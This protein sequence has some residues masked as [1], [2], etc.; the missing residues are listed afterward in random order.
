MSNVRTKI[1][2]ARRRMKEALIERD[3]EIDIV[4]ISLLIRENPLLV[5]PPGTAKSLLIDSLLRWFA[6]D[7]K[8]FSIIL[9]KFSVPEELFGPISL[10]E[11]KNGRYVRVTT[12][13]LPEAHI[14][15]IDE[16]FKASPAILNTMLRILN[17]RVFEQGD[18][19]FVRCPL[20]MTLAASNEWP[21]SQ[22]LAALFDRFLLRKTVKTVSRDNR[23]K[24]L[25]ISDH[26]PKFDTTIRV[27]ELEAAVAEVTKIEY[28]ND[29]W[30]ALEEILDQLNDNGIFPGDRRMKKS[31]NI[32]RAYA[33]LN[34]SRIVRREHLEPLKFSLWNSPDQEQKA[35]KVVLSICNPS[36]YKAIEYLSQA[37]QVLKSNKKI[38]DI[39]T[40]LRSIKEQLEELEDNEKKSQVLSWIEDKIKRCYEKVLGIRA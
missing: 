26:T 29:A 32:A 24:L 1:L 2:S 25:R 38:E 22:E 9:S 11:L 33:Y 36:A 21:D 20:L 15:F 13:K 34:G 12:N 31:V 19:T 6:D 7:L 30:E 18:G 14:A 35:H 23:H 27:S 4:F 3:D 8:K 39:V 40:E 16:I 37:M 10:P 28:S 5:G 17:E